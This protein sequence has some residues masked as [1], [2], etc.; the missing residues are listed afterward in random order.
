VHTVEITILKPEAEAMLD[1]MEQ[2]DLIKV[3][4]EKNGRKEPLKF[5]SFPGLVVHMA[6]DFNDPLPEFE[7]Y[8]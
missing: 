3:E 5:G 7:D 1:E 2:K 8:M 4:H 6:D